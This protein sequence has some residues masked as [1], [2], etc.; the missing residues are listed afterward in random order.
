[1]TPPK[2][3][4]PPDLPHFSGT[5][6]TPREEG[7]FEQWVFQ[8]RGSR[9][10]HTEDAVRS[11]IINSVRGEARDQVEYIG[12]T[13]PL[14]EILERLESRFRKTKSTD[15]LQ[16]DFFQMTQEKGEGVQQFA[17]RLENQFK[18]LKAVF[19]ERYGN[20]Q[21]ME[22]LYFGMVTGLRNATRYVY[23]LPGA[24]YE[25][26]LDAAREAEL[27][28]QENRTVSARA[29]ALGVVDKPPPENPKIQELSNKLESLTATLKANTLKQKSAS[30]PCSPA[31]RSNGNQSATKSKGPEVTSHGP[32]RQGRKPIQCYK[33]GGW[34]HGWKDCPSPGNL[35]WRRLQ[36]DEPPPNTSQAPNQPSS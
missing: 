7:S 13:A 19:P 16:S 3:S 35:D 2:V 12:F 6:P 5:E 34:G 9:A 15:R 14:D 8:V 33:C 23:K 10:H 29:K 24:T 30:A 17:G 1:M 18:K 4:K 36:G 21:L 27:E 20:A 28:F 22:R 25:G 26:L 32:F 31:K 11:G